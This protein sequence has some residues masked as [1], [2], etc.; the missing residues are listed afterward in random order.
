MGPGSCLCS[1]E[2]HKG[3]GNVPW[4]AEQEIFNPSSK[5]IC[6]V[7]LDSWWFGSKHLGLSY[8]CCD[9]DS[10]D[11]LTLLA[12]PLATPVRVTV[13]RIPRDEK[14]PH[15]ACSAPTELLWHPKED[16]NITFPS[17]VRAVWA[18]LGCKMGSCRVAYPMVIATSLF[19]LTSCTAP[20][21]CR[22]HKA[23]RYTAV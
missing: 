1:A 19:P 10:C 17:P 3:Q 5:L 12:S 22:A 11:A 20:W 15:L 14:F 16:P 6:S 9:A 13:D 18:A 23:L 21:S 4:W 8:V 7:T 2:A